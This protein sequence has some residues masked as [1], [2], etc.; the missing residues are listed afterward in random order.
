MYEVGKRA[1]WPCFILF[2]FAG[3]ARA[4]DLG[5]YKGCQA[6]DQNFLIENLAKPLTGANGP[7]KLTVA[8]RPDHNVE[9][10]F[11]E[12]S[13]AVRKFDGATGQVTT[14]GNLPA[15]TSNEDGLIGIALDPD[16]QR[17]RFIYFNYSFQNKSGQPA[18]S[19]FRISR[20]ALA[21]DGNIDPASEKILLKI[22]SGR[23]HWHTGGVMSFDAKGNLWIAVGDNQTMELGPGNTKDLRGAILRIH[24][25][26]GARGYGVPPGNFGEFFAAKY[27]ASGNPL[28]ADDYSDSAKVRPELYIKGNRNVYTLHSDSVSGRML[29]SEFGP[30]PDPN[31][32]PN[33]AVPLEEFDVIKE[34]FYGGWPYFAARYEMGPEHLARNG[35][36]SGTLYGIP[37]PPIHDRNNIVNNNPDVPVHKLP[38][39]HNAL[40]ERTK[41]CPTSG[42]LFRYDGRNLPPSGFPPQFDRKWLVADCRNVSYGFHLWSMNPSL[43]SITGDVKIFAQLSYP[44]QIVDMQHGPDGVLYFVSYEGGLFRIRYT[45]ACKDAGLFPAANAT[46]ILGLRDAGWLRMRSRLISIGSSGAHSISLWDPNGVLAFS[47]QGTIPQE[48]RVPASLR[49]GLY[50][51][52][53]VAAEGVV[54]AKIIF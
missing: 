2:S 26:N 37:I 45:G 21:P 46:P 54:T 19:S 32:N 43:D 29:F 13:G 4:V 41:G 30:D 51:L 23:N 24:P 15:A 18:E 36:G 39:N 35:A 16:F 6:S 52:K 42:P 40:Y 14:I 5:T 9:V 49:P 20:F 3:L 11:T 47:V 27:R 28:L 48:Y 17:N 44:G 34:P 50:L 53:V 38:P 7:T 33:N 1:L 12:K 25:D 8:E 31:T 22:P 10:Y